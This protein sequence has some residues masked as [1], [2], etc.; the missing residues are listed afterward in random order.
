MNG[1]MAFTTINAQSL[2]QVLTSL[3][4][5]EQYVGDPID[6]IHD[7]N[8]M[9]DKTIDTFCWVEGTYTKRLTDVTIQLKTSNSFKGYL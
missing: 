4:S 2:K 7:I 8:G 5:F 9:D 1:T 3:I 6:C